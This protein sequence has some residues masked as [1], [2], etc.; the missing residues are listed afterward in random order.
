MV[1][2]GNN[3]KKVGYAF[4]WLTGRNYIKA[5]AD[6]IIALESAGVKLAKHLFV[7][8]EKLNQAQIDL[9]TPG[10]VIHKANEQLKNFLMK[11]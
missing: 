11:K 10:T 7:S 2:I 6:E 5:P 8:P 4:T 1:Y 9:K 3:F